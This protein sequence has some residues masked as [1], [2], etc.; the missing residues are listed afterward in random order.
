[1]IRHSGTSAASGLLGLGWTARNLGGLLSDAGGL[2]RA[3]RSRFQPLE[4]LVLG[5]E[6]GLGAAALEEDVS[7][8]AAMARFT[9][10]ARSSVRSILRSSQSQYAAAP[11]GMYLAAKAAAPTS[12][13]CATLRI[14]EWPPIASRP[15]LTVRVRTGCRHCTRNG[16]YRFAWRAAKY[17]RRSSCTLIVEPAFDCPRRRKLD[18]RPPVYGDMQCGAYF[19]GPLAPHRPPDPPPVLMRLRVLPGGRR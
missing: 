1:M 12:E 17:G 3:S 10:S 8:D 11:P 16:N 6:A 15:S 7:P 5:L 9:R 13:G 14:C 18:E 2:T 19:L 4:P